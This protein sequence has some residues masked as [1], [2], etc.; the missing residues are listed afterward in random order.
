MRFF[1]V[2]ATLVALVSA[3]PVDL[4]E[5][6][7]KPDKDTVYIEKVSWAGTGCPPGSATYDIVESGTLISLAFSKYV[8][9]T[10]AG[11]SA[12]DA[13]KNCD[14]RI[15]LHY[16]QGWTWTVAT[17]DLRGYAR[18]PKGCSA[19]L[20]S[21]YW[22]SG[23]Q[24]EASAMVPFSGPVDANYRLTTTIPNESLVW[25]TCGV[26]GPLFNVNSQAIV[27]CSGQDSIL[28]VDSQDTKFQML[29]H[30]S[31]KKC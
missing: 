5:R 26:T 1:T 3:S 17:T 14:V 29:L 22:F 27:T 9:G 6:Q 24:K 2:F 30:L 23:Q 20:G 7:T 11:M 4:E 8:A 21:Q 31:W 15:T 18:I 12:T 10:G 16:P 25:S 13:R 19:R 28:G